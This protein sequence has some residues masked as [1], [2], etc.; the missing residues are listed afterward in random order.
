M[1]LPNR[2]EKTR[3]KKSH[4]R[5][6]IALYF[7]ILILFITSLGFLVRNSYQKTFTLFESEKILKPIT[8][9]AP[10]TE[11]AKELKKSN[12]GVIS[13][14]INGEREILASL[15]G[16]TQVIFKS[17]GIAQQVSSLQIM[18]SRFKIEGRIPKKIDLRFE[19]PIVVF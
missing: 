7:L 1:K 15:S 6:K 9:Q 8:R 14:S 13:L 4:K 5:L 10:E 17:E 16:D 19:K 3:I 18:L 11:L 2:K 12:L